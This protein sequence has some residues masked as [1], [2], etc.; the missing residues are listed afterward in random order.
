[1]LRESLE[2]QNYRHYYI[3]IDDSLD[4]LI[5]REEITYQAKPEHSE[6]QKQNRS[7][8]TKTKTTNTSIQDIKN[9][10]N[11]IKDIT[12]FEQTKKDIKYTLK[13]LNHKIIKICV[14]STMSAGKSSRINTLIGYAYLVSSQKPTPAAM[15]ALT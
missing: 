7:N 4:K 3:H 5:D 1:N 10:L 15:T 12:L 2:T 11:L 13:Q 9:S 8:T 14:F 6:V